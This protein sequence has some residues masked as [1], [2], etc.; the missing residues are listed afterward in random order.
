MEVRIKQLTLFI[1]QTHC[2]YCVGPTVTRFHTNCD[3]SGQNFDESDRVR[4]K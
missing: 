4:K 1:I 3:G 2:V